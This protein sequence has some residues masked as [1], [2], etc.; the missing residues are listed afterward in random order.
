MKGPI[1]RKGDQDAPYRGDETAWSKRDESQLGSKY[2]LLPD[3]ASSGDD[4]ADITTTI[5]SQ[6]EA[7]HGCYLHEPDAARSEEIR[8]GEQK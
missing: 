8:R 7:N 6:D 4:I 2:A 5:A 1:A 3:N